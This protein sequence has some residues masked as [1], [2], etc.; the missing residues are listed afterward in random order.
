MKKD[1][2][3][4]VDMQNDFIGGVLGTKEAQD[5][6]PAVT[7]RIRKAVHDGD[8]IIYTRDTH[9]KNYLST[10]EGKNLPVPHCIRGSFGWQIADGIPVVGEIVDKPAFGSDELARK[11]KEGG[12]DSAELVGVCTDICVISNALLIRSLCPETEVSVRADCCAGVT[13]ERHRVALE[14]MRACQIKII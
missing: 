3:V 5:I 6:L 7:G 1:L 11:V 2:L 13:P 14:A 9:E 10:Q 4:V 12:Y 8:D